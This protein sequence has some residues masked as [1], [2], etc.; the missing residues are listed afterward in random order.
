[1]IQAAVPPPCLVLTGADPSPPL[2][3]H[4][5]TPMDNPHAELGI[6][7]QLSSRGRVTKKEDQ[8]KKKFP[9]AVQA[10]D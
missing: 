1:M 9:L 5:L 2:K 8:K 6:K 10:T 7:P 3:P 4:K